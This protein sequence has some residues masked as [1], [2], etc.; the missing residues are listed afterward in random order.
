ML[1]CTY[2]CGLTPPTIWVR[3]SFLDALG[4]RRSSAARRRLLQGLAL[5]VAAMVAAHQPGLQ[6]Q[7]PAEAVAAT[8]TAP[9]LATDSEVWAQFSGW[10]VSH[11]AW[12][13]YLVLALI[14]VG[15]FV[16]NAQN[17]TAIGSWF[18]Q[19]WRWLRPKSKEISP[20][21]PVPITSGANVGVLVSG[22][23][24]GIIN[25][26]SI[27]VGGNQTVIAAGPGSPVES[28]AGDKH[29]HHY[30]PAKPNP[31]PQPRI[32]ASVLNLCSNMARCHGDVYNINSIIRR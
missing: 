8:G 11:G 31:P 27:S 6:A 14:I 29:V 18:P 25:S 30:P 12:G 4:H 13:K 16:A 20:P 22:T 10:L 19:L 26:G 21:S 28:I 15:S 2:H 9:A 7:G 32:P 1:I 5:V 3:R 17:F 24:Q 23:A